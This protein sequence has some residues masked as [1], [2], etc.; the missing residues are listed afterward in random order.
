MTRGEFVHQLPA[1]S[2]RIDNVVMFAMGKRQQFC[3]Q[4]R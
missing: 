2:E 1:E 3:A 4:I